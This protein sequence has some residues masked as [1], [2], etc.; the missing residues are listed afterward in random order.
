MQETGR[1]QF[2][3]C[4]AVQNAGVSFFNDLP[5]TRPYRL[6]KVTTTKIQ[7]KRIAV[8]GGGR[9]RCRVCGRV[10]LKNGVAVQEGGK[11]H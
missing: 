4:V 9:P 5:N 2:R 1:P 8:Q 10:K 11:L 3:V 7:Q 6:S